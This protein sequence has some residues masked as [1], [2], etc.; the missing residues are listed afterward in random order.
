VIIETV[1]GRQGLVTNLRVLRSLPGLDE[2]AVEAVSRWAYTPTLVDGTPAEVV[3]AVIVSF[4][5]ERPSAAVSG[6]G[7]VGAPV[8]TLEIK[9]DANALT[10]VERLGQLTSEATYRLDGRESRNHP[11]AVGAMRVSASHWDGDRLVTI[12]SAGDKDKAGRVETMWLDGATLVIE[13]S[14]SRAGA[15]PVTWR[16]IYARTN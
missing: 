10:E 3:M 14:I 13:R 16:T 11:K 15:P 9:Q 1:I 12:I 7:G 4:S 6:R 8:S 5:L 2:A